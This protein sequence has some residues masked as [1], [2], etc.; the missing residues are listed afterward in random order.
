MPPGGHE[1]NEDPELPSGHLDAEALF[2]R[3]AKFVARFLTR[4][5]VQRQEIDDLV[6]EVFLVAHRR[7]GWQPGP[8]QPTTWLAEITLRVASSER[9]KTGRREARVNL[10]DADAVT[11]AS[12]PDDRA[13]A[14]ES[15]R[16]VE[17]ALADLSLDHRGVFVLFELEGQSCEEIAAGLGIPVG[18]V[19]SRLHKARADFKRSYEKI[20]GGSR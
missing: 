9:R 17:R 6:Q 15:L 18:T 20:S 1:P 2:Q 8:A 16:R 19:Y 3:H 13:A 14:N 11:D 4:L 5:G 10:D 12:L 7:G